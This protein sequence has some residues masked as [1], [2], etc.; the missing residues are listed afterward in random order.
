ME[1]NSFGLPEQV[2]EWCER[3]PTLVKLA[4]D[5]ADAISLAAEIGR[6][7]IVSAIIGAFGVIV[8]FAAVG[9]FAL[10]NRQA[11]MIARET[12]KV[13]T[14]AMVDDFIAKDARPIILRTAL[15]WM[16]ENRDNIFEPASPAD[17]QD[18]MNA[19]ADGPNGR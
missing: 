3:A 13:E 19:L 15:D 10:I 8:A 4:R 2:V 9:W 16:N 5:H 18:M 11:G 12:A 17:V 1:C 6:F 7:D 14:R